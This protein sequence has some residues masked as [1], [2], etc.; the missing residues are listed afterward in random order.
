MCLIGRILFAL[1]YHL[2]THQCLKSLNQFK[3]IVDAGTQETRQGIESLDLSAGYRPI[4]VEHLQQTV[5]LSFMIPNRPDQITLKVRCTNRV[6]NVVH[7]FMMSLSQF[8]ASDV[9]F[10]DWFLIPIAHLHLDIVESK[11]IFEEGLACKA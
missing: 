4:K 3:Y 2:N 7:K 8:S 9:V 10:I 11:E 1:D 6:V 5:F